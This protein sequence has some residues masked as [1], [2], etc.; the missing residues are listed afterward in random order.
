MHDSAV[1]P[2]FPAYEDG[3]IKD[4]TGEEGQIAVNEE[5]ALPRTSPD[6]QRTGR[7]DE[8]EKV[9]A[10]VGGIERG[11]PVA[12]REVVARAGSAGG[13]SW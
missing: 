12:R 7:S 4:C 6:G 11:A 10:C 1:R 8:R 5:N 2:E 9:E 3:P 13:R